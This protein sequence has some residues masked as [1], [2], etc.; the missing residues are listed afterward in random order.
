MVIRL[1]EKIKPEFSQWRLPC[2]IAMV[3]C[4][5]YIVMNLLLFLKKDLL[6]PSVAN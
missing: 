2:R 6:Q 5:G 4:F 3:F 1:G